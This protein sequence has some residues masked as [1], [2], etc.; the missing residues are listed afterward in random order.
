MKASTTAWLASLALGAT[1]SGQDSPRTPSA[2]ALRLSVEAGS[3]WVSKSQR[4]RDSEGSR[5]AK[6]TT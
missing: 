5:K 4:T 1:G 6:V 2:Y 3:G